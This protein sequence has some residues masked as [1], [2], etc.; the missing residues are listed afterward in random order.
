[1]PKTLAADWLVWT[2]VNWVNFT[3]MPIHYQGLY[4]GIA[5]FFFNI[6]FSYIAFANDY[7]HEE[8]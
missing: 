4:V 8:D 2:P 6:L 5:T 1:M 7:T 3:Y